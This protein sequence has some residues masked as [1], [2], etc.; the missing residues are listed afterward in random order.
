MLLN[1]LKSEIPPKKG[2]LIFLQVTTT[3][4]YQFSSFNWMLRSNPLILGHYYGTVTL[5]D[6]TVCP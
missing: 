1:L 2:P 3:E 4:D 6:P 5:K